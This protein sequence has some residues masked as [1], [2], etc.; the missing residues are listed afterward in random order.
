VAG[1]AALLGINWALFSG[2][3]LGIPDE[4]KDAVLSNDI[5]RVKNWEDKESYLFTPIADEPVTG[6]ILYPEGNLDVRLYA[7]LAQMIAREDYQVTFLSRRFE[8]EKD[9]E[10][11][12]DRMNIVIA[13]H[14]GIENWIVGGLTWS[15]VLPVDFALKNTDKVDAVI[16]LA[17]RLDQETSLEETDLPVLYI[18]G[19][20]DDE[21][22]DLLN[23]Q[24]PF[25]PAHTVYGK[26][27][28]GNRLQYGY[29]GPMPRD[30]AANISV[31]EQQ[32]AA[33]NYIIAF[34]GELEK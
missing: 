30:V 31:D 25:L 13:S 4:V 16:L 32:R 15:S 12:A 9:F 1:I 29:T 5:V 11:E 24:A 20:R 34:L 23:A 22:E 33:A 8:R 21:N 7:P 2:A 3:I 27:K 18:Y 19:T 28:G 26:I 14:P 17:S 6:L 10:A